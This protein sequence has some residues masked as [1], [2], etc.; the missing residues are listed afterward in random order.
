MGD[1]PTAGGAGDVTWTLHQI[2]NHPVLGQPNGPSLIYASI[3][4]PDIIHKALKAGIGAEIEGVAGAM[5]DNRY[6]PPITLKGKVHAIKKGDRNAVV[7]V[8]LQINNNY[9]IVTERRKP[10]HYLKD[11]TDLNL[12]PQNTSIVM[13]KIGYLVPELYQIQKGWL[14]ALTPGGVDQD[15]IRLPYQRLVRPIFPLDQDMETPHL[16]ATLIPTASKYATGQ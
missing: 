9:I 2:V 5:V 12:N 14:M 8:V 10:Y 15:L 13:V 4:G 16:K 3:P 7:E 11:F 1:N 6:A